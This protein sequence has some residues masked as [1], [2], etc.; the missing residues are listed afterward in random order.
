VQRSQ[1]LAAMFLFGAFLV[2]GTLGFT[3]DR[4][5]GDR[6]RATQQRERSVVDA[7]SDELE[8]TPAQRLAVDS[9]LDERNRVMD[10]M[11]VPIRPALRAVRDDARRRIALRL[12]DA[13]RQR[14]QAYVERMARQEAARQDASKK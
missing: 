1:Q 9:I 2:G 10:S 11:M 7:F 4:V 13:Q 12:T 14:F 6:M 8:L 5:V 3:V